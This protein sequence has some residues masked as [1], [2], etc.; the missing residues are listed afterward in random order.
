[1]LAES[2]NLL[3]P[4]AWAK[5][6]IVLSFWLILIMYQKRL[7]KCYMGDTGLLVSHAFSENEIA[8]EELYKN[9]MNGRLSLNEGMLYENVIS[10]MLYSKGRKLFFYTEYDR[11][12]HRNSMEIDF[13]LSNE[14]KTKF[15][16]FPI[17]VKSA[18]NYTTTSLLDFKK[19]FGKKIGCCY[20]IH[21]KAYAKR[22]DGII[23]I[24]PYM[25]M[26]L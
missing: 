23:C 9:I 7:L 18:K 14:S 5:E 25:A 21:P 20:I 19:K 1:M 26:C 12:S 10:Q 17:E 8:S 4:S 2:E 11:K 3:L 15:K 6:S 13:L 22:K 24:P 16:V